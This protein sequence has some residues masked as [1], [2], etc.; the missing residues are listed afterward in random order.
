MPNFSLNNPRFVLAPMEGVVDSIMRD[1]LTSVGDV[2]LCVTEFL[3]VTNQLYPRKVFLRNCPELQHN[4]Q[5][6][7]GVPV[8]I[9]LLGGDP[10]AMADNAAKAVRLG[11]SAIDLNFG[12]PAKTV[13]NSDG[14][15]TLLQFTDRLYNIVSAVRAAVPADTPVTAKMRLGFADKS[16]MLENALAIEAAGAQKLTVHG[17]TKVDG[18][19]PPADW[20]SIAKIADAL[21]IK[22]VPNGDINSLEN[23]KKCA[24]IIPCDEYM[25]GRGLLVRPGLVTQLKGGREDFPW[26]ELLPHIYRF[27]EAEMTIGIRKHQGNR[28]KQ[29]LAYLKQH[30][31]EAQTFFDVAKRERDPQALLDLIALEQDK[32]RA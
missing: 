27:Q 18:Y 26:A 14:G 7:S 5:T 19:K 11:A 10:I 24:A 22:V 1:I 28:L 29:W 17:R 15:A 30:Y 25:V 20:E 4:C 31:A 6:S 23:F 9:Q 16:L 2:D 12:C 21:R 32:Y 8:H 13:N 3:R